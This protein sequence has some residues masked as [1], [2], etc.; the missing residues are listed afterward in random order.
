[1]IFSGFCKNIYKRCLSGMPFKNTVPAELR[2]RSIFNAVSSFRNLRR[3]GFNPSVI[4]DCGAYEGEWTKQIKRI[5][6]AS[7]ILLIEAL[8]E[9]EKYLAKIK[10][11][12]PGVDYEIALLGAS[13]SEAVKFYRMNT[14]SSVFE[15]QSNVRRQE[16]TLP[17]KTLD[18]IV[19][20]RK[21]NEVSLLKLDVQGSE[22]E[23]LKGGS[24]TLRSSD[25]VL[26]ECSFLPYNK[27]APLFNEVVDF[28]AGEGFF[29]YDI[30]SLFRW[31]GSAMLQA[32]I[33]FA[34]EDSAL[35]QRFFNFRG[36]LKNG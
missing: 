18:R 26:L 11:D 20:A 34:R 13:N 5:F 29:V 24:N 23:V 36:I 15:E 14:G 35:R 1:M 25:M 21:I 22:I 8:P 2:S 30:G 4:I 10:R 6:P 7:Q 17:M 12:Y 33:I 32:D 28:M 19:S 31:K 16:V 27:G 9:K 3:N